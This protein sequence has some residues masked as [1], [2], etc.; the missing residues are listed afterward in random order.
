M[1]YLEIMIDNREEPAHI[2]SKYGTAC[3]LLKFIASG[4]MYSIFQRHLKDASAIKR[5]TDFLN[6]EHYGPQHVILIF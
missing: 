4:L 2:V 3:S 5:R 1:A 6:F